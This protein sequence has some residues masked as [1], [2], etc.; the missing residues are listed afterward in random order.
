M[1]VEEYI[2]A[3]VNALLHTQDTKI[4]MRLEGGMSNYTYGV[5][6][7]GKNTP[8]ASPASSPRSSWIAWTNGITSKKL[9]NLA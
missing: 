6:A 5:E 4:V 1:N 2:I 3:R 8:T 9:I 7:L